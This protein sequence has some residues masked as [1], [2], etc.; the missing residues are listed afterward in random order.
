MKSM[1]VAMYAYGM[2]TQLPWS[3]RCTVPL[4]M[5]FGPGAQEQWSSANT[6][7]TLG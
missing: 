1:P 2:M 5:P 4:A 6:K 7:P 3:K